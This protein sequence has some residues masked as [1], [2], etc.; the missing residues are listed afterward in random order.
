[1][2]LQEEEREGQAAAEAM[3]AE[4]LATVGH[5]LRSPLTSI[6]G[7]TATLL[8]QERR[9]SRQERQQFLLAIREASERLEAIIE[10]FLEMS[11]LEIG[12]INL[13]R[14]AVDAGRLAQ[15]ALL[16]AQQRTS[17]SL[18]GHFTFHLRLKDERGALTFQEPLVWADPRLL[19]EVLD[20][21]LDNAISYS[22]DGG[23]IDIVIRPVQLRS[24]G[25]QD[26]AREVAPGGDRREERNEMQTDTEARQMLDI[27]VCDHGLG[28]PDEHLERVFERFHRVDTRLTRTVNGLGL[29]L[30]ICK[31]I[32][33]MH[34]GSIWAESCPGGGSALHVLFPLAEGREERAS[35]AV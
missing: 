14:I 9:L 30:T 28:I 12:N 7:Y 2:E 25:R 18:P 23:R 4:V 8:R 15:E 17:D 29:G 1:M 3:N 16:N 5:E 24:A 13:R 27:C 34:G 31:R 33:E 6:K 10:R 19:R 32:I 11:Q 35:Q 21:L 26:G 20:N 22:P